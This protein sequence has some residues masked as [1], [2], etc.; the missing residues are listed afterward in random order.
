M[1]VE[2]EVSDNIA[3]VMLARP[4]RLN[5]I[6]NAMVDALARVWR[7]IRDRRD[8]RVAILTG[9]GD[10]AFCAGA[11][12]LEYIPEP[13]PI[14]DTW[15]HQA[16]LRPDRGIEL[17]KP[18]IAA[19]NGHCLGGGMTLLLATDIRLAVPKATFG[20]PEVRWGVL[21]SCG[22]TQRLMHELPS[23]LAMEMLLTGKP[24][25]AAT[26]E[27]RG[28][29]NRIVEPDALMKEARAV[30][31]QI[32]ANAPLAVQATKEL[33]LTSRGV[34]PA[35]GIRLEDAMVR[36]LQATEDVREGTTAFAEKRQPVFRGE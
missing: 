24:I 13:P 11:D 3:T 28:L 6:N 32:A 5:A 4:E 30:A 29:I 7:E 19:V 26:A 31:R 23:A 27:R 25:D 1:T 35:I 34:S 2:F 21:A 22:G 10:R 18:V 20:T 36:L 15:V 33:A 17:W 8:I 9:A 16:G 14:S 12:L